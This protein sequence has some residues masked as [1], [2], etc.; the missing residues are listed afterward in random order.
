MKEF[1]ANFTKKITLW[2]SPELLKAWIEVRKVSLEQS[3]GTATEEMIVVMEE[4]L[5]AIR[6]DVGHSNKGLK[7]RDILR[8]FI[9]DIDEHM[10]R[11]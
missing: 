4:F 9:N 7:K 10:S 11:R 1:F 2:G 3:G 8:T 5:L 6:A